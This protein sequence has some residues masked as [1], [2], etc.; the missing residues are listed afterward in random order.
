[1]ASEVK[2]LATQ[3]GR[4]TEDISGQVDHIQSSISEAV[5]AID[6]VD[7]T[8]G[9]LNTISGSIAAAVEEQGY[10]SGEISSNIVE[11]ADL[12]K[13][14]HKNTSDL[15]SIALKNGQSA[16]GMIGAVSELDTEITNLQSHVD[17]FISSIRVQNG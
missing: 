12:T 9:K 16:S 1:V 14:V 15:N 11:A 3:T 4:A 2:E 10:A 6:Q 17:G 8:I 5:V 7:E 13:D